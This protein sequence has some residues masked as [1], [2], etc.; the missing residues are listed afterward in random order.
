MIPS[1]DASLQDQDLPGQDAVPLLLQVKIMSVLQEHLRP[2]KLIICF[3]K[4]RL[5]DLGCCL[6][7]VNFVCWGAAVDEVP[8]PLR[9]LHEGVPDGVACPPDPDRLHHARVAQL[10][11]AQLSIEHLGVDDD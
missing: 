5:T 1:T 2:P 10:A 4:H 6:S 9:E 3:P 7:A 8:V 11:A